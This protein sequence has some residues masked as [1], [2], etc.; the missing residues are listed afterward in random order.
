ML[1]AALIGATWLAALPCSVAMLVSLLPRWNLPEPNTSLP[2]AGLQLLN[3]TRHAAV[4]ASH[5]IACNPPRQQPQC[6][7][8]YNHAPAITRL[9]N[10]ALVLGWHNEEYDEDS[11]GGRALFSTSIDGGLHWSSASVLR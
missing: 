6:P 7:G 1:L 2:L 8:T 9:A 5:S 11:G 10:G 3:G 4:F